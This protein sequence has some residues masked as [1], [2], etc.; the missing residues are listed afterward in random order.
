MLGSSIFSNIE[1]PRGGR[2]NTAVNF[3]DL[4]AVVRAMWRP[5]HA[6]ATC[7]ARKSALR[8]IGDASANAT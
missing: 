3:D 6:A 5:Q 1:Y 2:H 4:L 7:R 8:G